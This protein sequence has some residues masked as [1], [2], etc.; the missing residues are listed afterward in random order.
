MRPTDTRMNEH[1]RVHTADGA[2]PWDDMDTL[3]P[4]I[5][6]FRGG[7]VGGAM[8]GGGRSCSDARRTA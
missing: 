4:P 1:S 8:G 7:L 6:G 5:W 2:P 3:M